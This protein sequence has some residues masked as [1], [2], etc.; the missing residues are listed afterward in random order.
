MNP[1]AQHSVRASFPA[2]PAADAAEAAPLAPIRRSIADFLPPFSFWFPEHLCESAWIERAPFAFWLIDAHRPS[3][4]VELGTHWGFSFFAF[5]QV[6]KGLGLETECF[7]TLGSGTIMPAGTA[8]RCLPRSAIMTL[9][10]IPLCQPV[11]FAALA[12]AEGH[13]GLGRKK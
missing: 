7:A 13:F 2:K 9:R 1:L 10:T 11:S 4:L 5:C 8:R 12:K 3:T 6:V